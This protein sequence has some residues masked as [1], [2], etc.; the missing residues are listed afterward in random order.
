MKRPSRM[1]LKDN[2]AIMDSSAFE[3][4]SV[5]SD[6]IDSPYGKRLSNTGLVSEKYNRTVKF[7]IPEKDKLKLKDINETKL[8]NGLKITQENAAESNG[9]FSVLSRRRMSAP[10]LPP[11]AHVGKTSTL[12]SNGF[13]SQR[14]NTFHKLT[15]RTGRKSIHSDSS[16]QGYRLNSQSRTSSSSSQKSKGR[17]LSA[18]TERRSYKQIITADLTKT[19]QQISG[20]K[21]ESTV[22]RNGASTAVPHRCTSVT[23]LDR[24]KSKYS[25]KETVSTPRTLPKSRSEA[26]LTGRRRSIDGNINLP[27]NGS[28]KS[29]TDSKKNAKNSQNNKVTSQK[30]RING[31]RHYASSNALNIKDEKQNEGD[32]TYVDSDTDSEKDQRVIDWII[33]VNDV[34]EPPEE[35]LIEHAD[36]PPQRDTAIRIVYEGDS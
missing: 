23:G 11:I 2:L 21:D 7:I 34:A 29:L 5:S 18:G 30:Y 31:M 14:S 24:Q 19:I 8:N 6:S 20:V 22:M 10:E 27:R 25:L 4:F 3:V 15:L 32:E 26:Q 28:D 16:V 9:D 36:E 35:P 33:G 1:R 13:I 12:V 17:V